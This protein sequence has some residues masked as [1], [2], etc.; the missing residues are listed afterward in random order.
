MSRKEAAAALIAFTLVALPGLPARAQTDPRCT[1]PGI[2]VL[3]DPAGDQTGAPNTNQ[4]L[5]LRK[6]EMAEEYPGG[7]GQMVVTM[8]V[9]QLD[10]AALPPNATWRTSFVARHADL[11]TTT[12]FVTMATN[13]G[14]NPL[15]VSF[16]YGF[17]DGT[18]NR[19]VGGADSGRLDAATKTIT[20][21]LKL[22]KLKKPEGL[23][24]N[25]TL[26]GPAV[27]LSA[28]KAITSISGVTSI[29]VGVVGNGFNITVDSIPAT[30]TYTFAGEAICPD[31]DDPPPPPPPASDVRYQLYPAPNGLATTAGEPTVGTNWQTGRAMF[32]S[33]LQTLRVS[34]DDCTSPA[35]NLWE[36]VSPATSATSLDPILWTDH[37]RAPGDLTPQRTIVS[38]LLGVTSLS[39]LSDDDGGF[40]VP[41]QGAGIASGIDHQSIGGGPFAEPLPPNPVYPNAV[42]YCS[43][44]GVNALCALSVDGGLTYGPAVPLYVAESCGGLH[45]HP[46]VAPDGTVYVPNKSCGSR[47]EAAVVVST[48]NGI[49][50]DVRPVPGS[51][52]TGQLVD[53]S[54]DI[55]DRGTVYLGW[56]HGD[57]HAR[58]AVSRDRGLTWTDN[59]DVGILAG[60]QASVFPAVVAGDDDR[61]AYAFLGSTTAGDS[62][63]ESF[64][65][66]WYLY[67]AHTFDGGKTWSI[68]NAT[69]DDPVQRGS[70]C[71]LGTTACAMPPVGPRSKPDRNLLDFMDA[72]VDHEGRVLV[73]IADGCVTPQCIVGGP[74]DFAENGVIARQSGGRRLFSVFDPPNPDVP[75][76]PLLTA[77]RLPD[78]TVR[79]TW[80]QP[81]HGGSPIT[82][83]RVYVRDE[84]QTERQLLAEVTS[85]SYDD[86]TSDPQV[87][88][89]YAVTAV[90]AVG[91]SKICAEVSPVQFADPC[92]APGVQLLTDPPGDAVPDEPALDIL[93][94]FLAEPQTPGVPDQFLFTLRVADLSI[95]PPNHQWYI[96]W[97]HGTEL[98]KY[99]AALSDATGAV[100]FQYGEVS[101]PLST[102]D[103]DP[104]FNRPIPLGEADAGS[105]D[106]ARGLFTFSVA[107]SKVGNPGPGQTISN[108]SPRT[109]AGNGLVNVT[110]S[111]AADTTAITPSYTLAGACA[112]GTP[113]A[114]DDAATTG[115]NTAVVIEV[116]ANDSDN[117]FPP[118]TISGFSQ[119]ANGA[120]LDNGDGTLTYVPDDNFNSFD[121]GPDSFTYT[122]TNG[123]GGSAGATVTV[124][125]TPFCA[126]TPTGS[127][128]DTFEP[129]A[130]PGW[131]VDTAVNALGAASPTWQVI[132]DPLAE[133]LPNAFFSDGT[134]LSA[135]DDRLLAPPQNLSSASR[136]IFWHRFVLEGSFDGG[137]LE[138]ST[139]GGA[140]WKDVVA[141]G[142]SFVEG[143]YNGTISP[144]DG[145]LIAGR[146]A[147]TGF[148]RF[149]DA[150]NRVEVRLGAFAGTGVRVRFRLVADPLVPGSLPGGGWW[151]D[152]VQFTDTLELS[153]CNHPP[154]AG[155]DRATTE[156]DTPI[157]IPVLLNDRDP[158]GDDIFI[159][160]VE[161]PDFGTATDNGDGT[162]TY[163]PPAGFVSPPDATFSYT[164][165]DGEFEATAGV[166]VTVR[167]INRAPLAVDDD[168][169]TRRG[170]PVT[171]AVLSN[172]SDP[173]GD[174]ISVISVDDPPNGS[175]VNNGDGTITY[176]PDPGF[177]SPPDDTFQYT[178][179]DGQ[180]EASATV[181]VTVSDDNRDPV[182][183]DD[184][185]VTDQ[186]RAVVVDVLRNDSDPDGDSL[187]ITSVGAPSSGTASD[188]GD[189]TVTYTPAP[190]FTGSD[191]FGY[192]I[193][194]GRGGSASAT[195]TVVVRE[196][197]VA[198]D[199]KATGGGWIPADGGNAKASFGFNAQRKQGTARGRLTYDSGA[200]GLALKGTV[201][202]LEVAGS[203]ARFSGACTL[204]GTTPCTYEVDVEDNGEPGAGADLFTIRVF[205]AAGGLVHSARETL[206]GGNVQVH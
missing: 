90:N 14:A 42:Y 197:P 121:G 202:S 47:N 38:Q 106:T 120:V 76:T 64:P 192:S 122:I 194:D 111:T 97:D 142:G 188:N 182:A 46:K 105:V 130:A 145:S 55:G 37:F 61:A 1:P 150:M 69:P 171:I 45:G 7:I 118:L 16:N 81:D 133:S 100:S 57:G 101:P 41:N 131:Q 8:T 178:I 95:V 58:I 67:V 161:A 191:S 166:T 177:V 203:S 72:E 4:Q 77:E 73:S 51:G 93:E 5:D 80:L 124:E 162:I 113:I 92:T 198:G 85:L 155:A 66:D 70:I 63:A 62:S 103:P 82:G 176:T 6:V 201:S 52:A 125:V 199:V 146:T 96:I 44:D 68:L 60:V 99:V 127:F 185:A 75:G 49:T 65:G 30:G 169:A 35:R 139:D 140:T 36:D 190:G 179:S 83:Y 128:S 123:A 143:G 19:T 156:K 174:A 56:Q 87:L 129:E 116:L 22:S 138:V 34:F 159:V 109:F 26:T 152:N 53:P 184:A 110:G 94:A 79:L 91:E 9:S 71:T 88:S 168:A 74:N 149:I 186:D 29:L 189:G 33:G 18:I 114:R 112:P 117:G 170:E 27:D 205:D 40:W 187:S 43:Q 200:H 32:Q 148:S 135:K 39:S 195:V 126:F 180:L 119:P 84:G 173:D 175:A 154:L 50:W 147:W 160:S 107:K 86:V 157:A 165:S 206:G 115:E 102:G 153:D 31:D 17:V 15:G 13:S 167:D 59:Q 151:I 164:I 137:V 24:G 104:D 21:F 48:D 2:Q 134:T 183:E 196:T 98:R 108:I 172:D 11:T 23:A 25:Q 136:L 89:F 12:Y 193:T 163:A 141:G 10:P 78:G 144:S 20:V 28:G 3:T 181:R 132:T 204:G 158:D 54:V